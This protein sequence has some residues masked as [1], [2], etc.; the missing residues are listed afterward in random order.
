MDLIIIL[1]LL[2]VFLFFFRR[3]DAFVFFVAI[4]DIF[5]RIMTFIKGQVTD[6][7]VAS[8]IGRYFPESVPAIINHYSADIINT[9]LMWVLV[10][11]YII[12]EVLI[13]KSFWRRK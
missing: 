3:F 13:I 8:I 6:P 10:V 2:G 1:I 5:L 9:I 12:F 7:E 11:I 4:I